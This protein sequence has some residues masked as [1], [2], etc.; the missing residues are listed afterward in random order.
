MAQHDADGDRA[1][2]KA[3]FLAAEGNSDAVAAAPEFLKAWAKI[4]ADGDG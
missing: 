1:V 2:T 4:D 3:E